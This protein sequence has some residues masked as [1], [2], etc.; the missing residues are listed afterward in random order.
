MVKATDCSHCNDRHVRRR[1]ILVNKTSFVN[2]RGLFLDPRHCLNTLAK[3]LPSYGLAFLKVVHKHKPFCIPKDLPLVKQKKKQL[4]LLE[5]ET[6]AFYTALTAVWCLVLNDGY[7]IDNV[8]YPFH[9]P[10]LAP[11]S[12]SFKHLVGRRYRYNDGS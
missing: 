8:Q 10:G 1:C 7:G 5:V 6:N 12:I 9:F 11:Q 2:F 3:V 4:P